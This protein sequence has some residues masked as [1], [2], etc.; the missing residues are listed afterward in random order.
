MLI[1][2][3]AWQPEGITWM[4]QDSVFMMPHLGVLSTVYPEAAWEI[5]EKDCLVRL[6]SVIAPK[7]VGKFGEKVMSLKFEMPDG[8]IIKDS[9][10]FGEIKII[11]LKKNEEANVII[12]PHRGFDVGNGSGHKFEGIIMGGEV[13]VILDA[14]GRPMQMGL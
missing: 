8:N 14:R 9:I 3:D 4:F 7:G 12:E 2:T 5:F 6:G 13:G 11:K 1:L 10:N